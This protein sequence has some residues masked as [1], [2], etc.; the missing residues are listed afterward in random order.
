[1]G[2][3]AELLLFRGQHERCDTLL[4]ES[5]GLSLRL[6]NPVAAAAALG[7]RGRVAID[8]GDVETG[9]RYLATVWRD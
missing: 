8:R 4:K 5:I 7:A 2:I 9:Q 1:M 3:L 6:G